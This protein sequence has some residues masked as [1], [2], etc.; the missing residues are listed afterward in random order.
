MAQLNLGMEIQ[1]CLGAIRV[2]RGDGAIEN[3]TSAF[4]VYQNS[5]DCPM[6]SDLSGYLLL[7]GDF[8]QDKLV[9]AAGW[10]TTMMDDPHP[11][12]KIQA[13]LWKYG[14]GSKLAEVFTNVPD[15]GD[16]KS[17]LSSTMS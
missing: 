7:S 10:V 16:V 8:G 2:H 4:V 14:E 13:Q 5:D 11:G 1:D 6:G 3:A 17:Q 15:V 12:G 9:G